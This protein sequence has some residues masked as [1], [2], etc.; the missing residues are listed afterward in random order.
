MDTQKSVIGE[1]TNGSGARR[2]SGVPVR[3]VC[4]QQLP[5]RFGGP[6]SRRF[7]LILGSKA[8]GITTYL[9]RH[10]EHTVHLNRLDGSQAEL[11]WLRGRLQADD[12]KGIVSYAVRSLRGTKVLKRGGF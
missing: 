10:Q 9:R 8:K 12:V 4:R 6:P 11:R 7:F 1:S 3:E 5:L 2:L